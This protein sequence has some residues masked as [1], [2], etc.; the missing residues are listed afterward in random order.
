MQYNRQSTRCTRAPRIYKFHGENVFNMQT[1]K[2]LPIHT[3]T[4]IH[5]QNIAKA[6][7]FIWQMGKKFGVIKP[8][9]WM[10]H[11]GS[12][13]SYLHIFV[14]NTYAWKNIQRPEEE[15][16]R[17]GLSATSM[18]IL[19]SVFIKMFLN[20]VFPNCKSEH[21]AT[22]PDTAMSMLHS[23]YS[24]HLLLRQLSTIGL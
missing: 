17:T 14:T 13:L 7:K 4:Q 1:N 16:R 9:T 5:I 19:V 21:L 2:N 3:H 24:S 15:Q 22:V 6:A 8:S 11:H 18:E 20:L 10:I 23:F 12:N